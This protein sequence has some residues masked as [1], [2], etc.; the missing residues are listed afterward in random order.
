[1]TQG[2]DST[3]SGEQGSDPVAG[4][5]VP[6]PPVPPVE[7]P[8]VGLPPSP[9]PAAAASAPYPTFANGKPA[10]DEMGDP[11]SPLSRLAAT[12]LC[13]FLGYF[14]VHRFYVGKIGTGLLMI[15]TLGGLGIWVLI[16]L[17]MVIVGVF[18]DKQGRKLYNW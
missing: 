6:D 2:P 16:D 11:V 4:S 17:I 1:M 5:P 8:A 9:P 3:P 7:N 15:I 18:R 14:G 12:L 10:V 13:F